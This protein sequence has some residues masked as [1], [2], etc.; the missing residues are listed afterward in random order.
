MSSSG[1]VTF[2]TRMND[3]AFATLEY[4]Q[5]LALIKRNAQT[6]AGQA[7]VESLSPATSVAQLQRELAALA[8]C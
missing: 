1:V 5:L 6:E 7:R 8:Q 2:H 3:Q 4:Q